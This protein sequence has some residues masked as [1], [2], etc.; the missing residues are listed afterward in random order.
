MNSEKKLRLLIITQGVS[1]IVN[2]I[3]ESKHSLV[4]VVEAAGRK[5]RQKPSP[6]F[7]LLKYLYNLFKKDTN[8]LKLW[9]NRNNVPYYFMANGSDENLENWIKELNPDL[10]VV[11]SMSQLLKDNIYNIPLHGTINLHPSY[12]PKYRGPFP[13]FWMYYNVDLQPGV[14]I[15]YIDDGEDTGDIIYQEYFN[16]PLGMKSPDMLDKCVSDIGIK[17]LLKSLD[18]IALNKAPRHQQPKDSPTPRARLIRK[19]EHSTIIDWDN[20]PVHRIW[21]ILRGTES[22]LN[23][24]EPPGGIYKGQ[25]WIIENY[26][27]C[28]TSNL[29]I[30]K[31]YKKKL[32]YFIVCKNGIINLKARFSLKNMVSY[33]LR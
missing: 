10:I 8:S 24:I 7:L 12:L 30:G 31:V 2:P 29:V 11:Y 32:R 25:R 23:C 33:L 19:E 16:M 3:L 20:W 5:K 15:H 27:E 4:G 22:W 9:A 1:R 13:D 28:N 6:I 26:E 21:H 17:L 18:D 14:T